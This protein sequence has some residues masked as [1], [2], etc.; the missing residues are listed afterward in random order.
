MYVLSSATSSS[1]FP[2]PV[3]EF[4]L[5]V[6]DASSFSARNLSLVTLAFQQI[7]ISSSQT[8]LFFWEIFSNSITV[9]NVSLRFS[10]GCPNQVIGH[11]MRLLVDAWLVLIQFTLP[12]ILIGFVCTNQKLLFCY[13]TYNNLPNK[14]KIRISD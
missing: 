14:K 2:G 12:S 3:R 6:V 13:V 5:V 7:G 1:L 11:C 4:F 8:H 9:T 10:I